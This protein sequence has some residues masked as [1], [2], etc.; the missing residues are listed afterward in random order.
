M[1]DRGGELQAQKLTGTIIIL[2]WSAAR[3]LF[4]A[5]ARKR[6]AD[7]AATT[8]RRNLLLVLVSASLVPIYL[9]YVTPLLDRSGLVWPM[10]LGWM[11]DLVLGASVA[12][13]IWSHTALGENWS[14][15][16]EVAS[17]QTLVTSGPYH[18]VRH[19]MYAALLL[20]APG[21]LLATGNLLV[22]VPFGTALALMYLDRV[23]AEEQ[24]MIEVFGNEYRSYMDR[25]GRL[26]PRP[27]RGRD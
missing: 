8:W 10:W 18:W 17:A 27:Q 9:Y 25:T 14:V 4:W 2:V 7:I 13:F 5:R 22:A 19:P 15:G 1:S 26:I 11:G 3:V 21:L 6:Q 12:L 16:V 24:L 20:M 23:D